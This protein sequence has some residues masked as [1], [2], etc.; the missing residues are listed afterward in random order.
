MVFNYA[1]NLEVWF[2]LK[3]VSLFLENIFCLLWR[4]RKQNGLKCLFRIQ[5]SVGIVSLSAVL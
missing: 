2:V 1:F 5:S 3:T 4:N